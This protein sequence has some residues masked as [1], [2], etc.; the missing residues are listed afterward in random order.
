MRLPW[1]MAMS[2]VG[3]VREV[4]VV[5]RSSVIADTSAIF[6]LVEWPIKLISQEKVGEDVLST[7]RG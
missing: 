1:R 2:D 5:K 4:T 3:T 6:I 7:E